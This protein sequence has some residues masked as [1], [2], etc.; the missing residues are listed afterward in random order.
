MKKTLAAAVMICLT[1]GLIV[2]G[3][4]A[5]GIKSGPQVGEKVPGPFHPL[6]INGE[7]AGE[8]NC[9][10]CSNGSNP[11]AMVFARQCSEP[12]TKLIKR[13]D[14]ATVKNKDA[15]MGSFVVFCNDDEGLK[16]MLAKIAQDQNLKETILAIDNPAGPQK[17]NVSKDADVTV[18]LYLDHE[19]KANYAY[20]KGELTEKDIEKVVNDLPKILPSK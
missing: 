16:D 11:V 14:E 18:V 15:K 1:A 13:I 3:L 17:Y 2:S 7:K 4:Q 5:A 6:N 19:V 9:L 12:L 8:K 10:Y 20:K